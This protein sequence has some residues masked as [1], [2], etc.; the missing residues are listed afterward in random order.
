M[1]AEFDPKPT[2]EALEAERHRLKD[3]EHNL[4]AE[5]D[6]IQATAGR[7]IALM[8]QALRDAAARAQRREHELE[9]ARRRLERKLEG[10]RLARL[11][12][13]RERRGPATDERDLDRRERDLAERELRLTAAA[14]AAQAE[15]SRLRE[16]EKRLS[17]AGQ[18]VEEGEAL[19]RR[20]AELALREDELDRKLTELVDAERKSF[21]RLDARRAELDAQ[22]AE[23]ERQRAEAVGVEPRQA[24]SA[25]RGQGS[26]REPDVRAELERLQAKAATLEEGER[27]LAEA[28]SKLAASERALAA[29]DRGVVER[30][31]A[32]AAATTALL[33]REAALAPTE[34]EQKER[35]AALE[36]GEAELA[37]RATF[38]AARESELAERLAELEQREQE[39]SGLRAQLDAERRRLAG[40]A[41]RLSEAERRAPVEPVFQPDVVGFSEGLRALARRRGAPQP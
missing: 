10:G 30:E 15:A 19:A 25:A 26:A 8:Q 27:R 39:L 16:L 38:L 5:R 33:E 24:V 32:L 40:R 21:E 23:L 4:A 14:A 11:A 7:E 2:I 35:G 22:A 31:A 17:G 9:T 20:A 18:E 3:L 41:R 6:R 36:Q 37:A 1:A 13:A 34:T 28:H 29:K 12:G